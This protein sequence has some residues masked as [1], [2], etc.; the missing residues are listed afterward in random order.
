M[1]FCPVCAMRLVVRKHETEPGRLVYVCPK[2]GLTKEATILETNTPPVASTRSEREQIVVIGEE[3][4]RMQTMPTTKARCGRC[5]NVEA[6]WWM[7]QTRG[8]DES[9][10]QFYRCTNCGYTW[11]E[12][13]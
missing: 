7:V 1:E 5:Q 11:R 10:T 9:T 6:Y 13:A 4:A 3:E 8:A 2:C 12:M